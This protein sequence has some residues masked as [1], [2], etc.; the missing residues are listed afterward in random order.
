[1]RSVLYCC[2]LAFLLA[3]CGIKG[4]LYLPPPPKAP[5][6]RPA[7]AASAP[8]AAPQEAASAPSVNPSTY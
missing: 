7:P 1:M 2:T 3:A 8:V 6:A 5:T 4:G